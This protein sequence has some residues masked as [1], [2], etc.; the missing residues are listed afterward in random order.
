MSD[1]MDDHDDDDDD[2]VDVGIDVDDDD[3]RNCIVDDPAAGDERFRIRSITVIGH[4]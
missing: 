4:L 1:R 3:D 2:D